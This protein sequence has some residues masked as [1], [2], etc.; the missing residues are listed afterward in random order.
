MNKADAS[1]TL[2][3]P[4]VNLSRHAYAGFWRRFGAAVVDCLV[5]LFAVVLLIVP[6]SLILGLSSIIVWPISSALGILPALLLPVLDLKIQVLAW[7]YFALMESS[8][9][10]A[11]IGKK[12]FSVRVITAEGKPL[13][14]GRATG[15]HF[16]KYLSVIIWMLGFV[17][18]AFTPKKQ[19]LH[20]IIAETVVVKAK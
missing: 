19:A 15:R 12:L 8:S 20:D 3:K 11:T 5:L 18:A 13:S 6:L 9:W 17:L 10:Q 7:L 16:G 14:F 1:C 4:G 2:V